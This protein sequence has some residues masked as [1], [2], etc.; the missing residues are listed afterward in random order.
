[1][2]SQ[3]SKAT[4]TTV[5]KNNGDYLEKHRLVSSYHETKGDNK[6]K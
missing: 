4:E 5:F 2:K 6:T 1:M 3:C